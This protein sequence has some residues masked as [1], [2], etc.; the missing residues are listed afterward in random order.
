MMNNNVIFTAEAEPMKPPF[1]R[2]D[3]KYPNIGDFIDDRL[4]DADLDPNA[5]PYDSVREYQYEGSGSLAGSLSSLNSSST[6]GSQD[7]DYLNEWGPRFAKLA[8]L[9]GGGNED[10]EDAS[11]V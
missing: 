5:P 8:E 4:M 3:G 7:Y 2:P 10:E 1:V 6:D 9:Y 11:S